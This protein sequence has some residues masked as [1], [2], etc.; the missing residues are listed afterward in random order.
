MDS[1]IWL[2]VANVGDENHLIGVYGK[3]IQLEI[4]IY[5][6]VDELFRFLIGYYW[7]CWIQTVKKCMYVNHFMRGVDFVHFK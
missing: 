4:S 2:F 6:S 3:S 1:Q 7:G 5:S